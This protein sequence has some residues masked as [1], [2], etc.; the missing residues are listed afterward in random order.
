MCRVLQ[1]PQPPEPQHGK[2]W[3][4]QKAGK[5]EECCVRQCALPMASG[6]AF[7]NQCTSARQPVRKDFS[8]SKGPG[9]S[10]TVPFWTTTFPD[11]ITMKEQS[12]LCW[13]ACPHSHSHHQ[14]SKFQPILDGL[15]SR[16]M[17]DLGPGGIGLR[18]SFGPLHLFG[19]STSSV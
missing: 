11:A 19:L 16:G 18:L 12:P 5:P 17:V 6:F 1:R 2:K 13:G 4:L 3:D 8:A 10:T 14:V 9:R 7:R 15:P